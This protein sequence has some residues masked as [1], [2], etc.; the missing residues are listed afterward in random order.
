MH[1]HKI[2]YIS[3]FAM[4]LYSPLLLNGE[5]GYSKPSKSKGFGLYLAFFQVLGIIHFDMLNP[6]HVRRFWNFWEIVSNHSLG[7]SLLTGWIYISELFI[8]NSCNSAYFPSLITLELPKSPNSNYL[9]LTFKDSTVL[10]S[11][12]YVSCIIRW[13]SDGKWVP[14]KLAYYI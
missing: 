10:W 5:A 1:F 7:L 2:V 12:L 8:D 3:Y 6:I 11:P 4:V 9:K 13:I 14:N